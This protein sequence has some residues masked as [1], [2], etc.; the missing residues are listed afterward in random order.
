MYYVH[1]LV[2]WAC[3]CMALDESNGTRN[4]TPQSQE[5]L[6]EAE[7]T[8]TTTHSSVVES[9]KV[10][11]NRALEQLIPLYGSEGAWSSNSS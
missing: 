11:E 3:M 8:S 5:A 1:V 2:V 10:E 7:Q 4:H 6:P 9:W